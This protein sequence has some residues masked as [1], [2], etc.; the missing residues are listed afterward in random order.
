M[1]FLLA[2]LATVHLLLV[3]VGAVSPLINIVY[4]WME[5]GEAGSRYQLNNRLTRFSIMAWVG[6]GIFGVLLGWASW[7]EEL[8]G[9]LS[10]LS[11]KVNYGII[12]YFFSLVL[13]VAY[14]V[15][16]QRVAKPGVVQRAL[17]CIFPLAAGTNSIYHFPVLFA[18]VGELKRRGLSTGD[19]ITASEFRQEWL[20]ESI[21]WAKS[22]HV[23][24]AGIAVTGMVVLMI[25]ARA[26]RQDDDTLYRTASLAG[27]RMALLA[28][29]AQV[30]TGF[31]LIMSLAP[32][33][34]KLL[35]GGDTLA[36]LAFAG[37]V[38]LAF[39]WMH[40]LGQGIITPIDPKS[41]SRIAI[42]GTLTML[43]MVTAAKVERM[44]SDLKAADDR[45]DTG[46]PRMIEGRLSHRD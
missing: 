15:W 8:S 39:I 28:L 6:G 46:I 44:N 12:E 37:G 19:K 27:A 16:R 24:I 25:A 21:V 36:T 9:V 22:I 26:K 14:L 35:M 23:V 31:W 32:S 5:P 30:L 34:Q 1:I 40:L 33:Q 7:S 3:S 45:G 38:F 42:I 43:L 2:I 18:V 20:V 4:E 10:R 11:S 13:M 29:V 17:R 41:I